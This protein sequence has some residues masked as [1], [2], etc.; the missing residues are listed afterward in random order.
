VVTALATTASRMTGITTMTTMSILQ[1][2]VR[3]PQLAAVEG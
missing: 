3:A 2:P 1:A